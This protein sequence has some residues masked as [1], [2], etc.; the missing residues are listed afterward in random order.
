[1][2]NQSSIAKIKKYVGWE[3]KPDGA[4]EALAELVT[5]C[6][7]DSCYEQ[8]V[9]RPG[10]PGNRSFRRTRDGL[11]YGLVLRASRPRPGSPG[12]CTWQVLTRFPTVQAPKKAMRCE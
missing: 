6:V 12:I 3:N 2:L 8:A 10:S 4:I 1:M 9:R 5:D 11:R 7:V